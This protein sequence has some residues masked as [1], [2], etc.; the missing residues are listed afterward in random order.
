MKIYYKL[1]KLASASTF[2]RLLLNQILWLRIP[3]NKPH[4]IK[5]TQVLD[6][7]FEVRLPY[8]RN[9]LN[10][11]KGIHACALATTSE[12]VAGLT[13]I[14]FLDPSKYR[15]ILES[16]Q[17]RY[18]YQAKSPVKCR[19]ELDDTFVRREI[20]EPLSNQDSVFVDLKTRITDE[21]NQLICETTTR[22]QIKSWDKVKTKV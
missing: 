11:L 15:L 22:W 13:L 3:F 17:I 19:F 18:V 9:N 21:S 10:H 2:Y 5:I 16:L 14:R 7:G 20:M 8:R 12:Y 4:G 1:L 6:A